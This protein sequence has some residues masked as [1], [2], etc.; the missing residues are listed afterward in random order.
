MADQYIRSGL[1]GWTAVP[2]V[3][4][5]VG[6]ELFDFVY[7]PFVEYAWQGFTYDFDQRSLNKVW[8]DSD[9]V[10]VAYNNGLS[11]ISLI[12]EE[13]VSYISYSSGFTDVW[14]SDS[15]VFVSTS[16]DGVKYLDKT[17]VSGSNNL[18]SCLIDFAKTNT[19]QSNY[20]ISVDGCGETFISFC[21]LSG[22]DFFKLEPNGFHSYTTAPGAELCYLLND[23]ELYYTVSGTSASGSEYGL[24]KVDPISDWATANL[25]YLTGSG[26][27]YGV[28]VLTDLYVTENTSPYGFYNTIMLG[29]D[30]GAYVIDEYTNTCMCITTT[31]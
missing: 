23:R 29:T 1:S 24:Y 30:V 11:I 20:V 6:E 27:L 26:I 25:L 16:D 8:S 18:T 13:Q 5:G 21:T 14:A 9:Y 31:S 22:V 19:I 12:S 10:Y 15:Y 2:G 3:E 4:W 17:L 28:S 7:Y